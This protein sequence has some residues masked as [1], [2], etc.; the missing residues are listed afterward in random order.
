MDSFTIKKI[1]VRS[2]RFHVRKATT[3][4]DQPVRS[5]RRVQKRLRYLS[6][7]ES[8]R[9]RDSGGGRSGVG[10][11]GRGGNFRFLG[12]PYRNLI[13]LLGATFIAVGI[14]FFGIKLFS[15]YKKVKIDTNAQSPVVLNTKNPEER[16]T[17]NVLITGYGGASH[18][19]AYLTD[20]I[21]MAHINKKEKKVILF[22]IPRDLWVRVPLQDNDETYFTKIN[23]LYQ[24]GLYPNN[25]PSLPKKYQGKDRAQELLKDKVQDITGIRPDY[26]VGVDFDGFTEIIDTLG[27]I[28]VNV[29]RAF[30]D[31]YYPIAGEEDNLCGRKPKPTMTPDE[32]KS[33]QEKLDAM[34]EEEKKE[35]ESR[36]VEDYTEEEFQKLAEEDP[37]KAY[38][39]RYEHLRFE[40]GMQTMDGATALKFARSRKSFQDGGDFARAA[41]QQLVIEAVKDKI[42]SVG[43]VTRLLPFL[44]TISNNFRTDIPFSEMQALIAEAANANDYV[45]SRYVFSTE[46]ALEISSSK[47]GQ[48]IVVSRDGPDKWSITRQITNNVIKG[49]SPTPTP[50][51]TPPVTGKPSQ[52]SNG[53]G[54]GNRVGSATLEE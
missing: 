10:S 5:S 20:T 8:G 52:R 49:I 17:L 28:E 2:S 43:F 32:L 4:N 6:G 41:R 21:I 34:N 3:R 22:S 36:P 35:Y 48:S 24:I 42:L 38:P 44:D 26:F 18:D 50:S 12:L 29:Q 25:Y 13:L 14:I 47:D 30:D 16:H 15:I 54:S 11:F 51:A 33:Y 1:P 19:G 45:I 27:G 9:G 7:G 40:A 39:C 53:T 37:L 23:A 46:E 31:Y